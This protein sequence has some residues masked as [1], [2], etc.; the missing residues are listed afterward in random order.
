M[1]AFSRSVE[2]AARPPT[3]WRHATSRPSARRARGPV[4]TYDGVEL[5]PRARHPSSQEIRRRQRHREVG[6]DLGSLVAVERRPGRPRRSP[7]PGGSSRNREPSARAGVPPP[8]NSAFVCSEHPVDDRPRRHVLAPDHTM[9]PPPS[10]R[11]GGSPRPG[12]DGAVRA[13]KVGAITTDRLLRRAPMMR[14]RRDARRGSRTPPRTGTRGLSSRQRRWSTERRPRHLHERSS[15]APPMARERDRAPLRL[16]TVVNAWGARGPTSDREIAARICVDRRG[17][18]RRESSRVGH[19]MATVAHS[20][21]EQIGSRRRPSRDD[22]T[23]VP[24]GRSRKDVTGRT[25]PAPARAYSARERR[26]RLPPR[27]RAAQPQAAVARVVGLLR[28]LRLRR[29]PRHRVQRDPRG[30]RADRRQPALQ[31]RRRRPRCR[32]PRRPGDHPRRD[33]AHA[34]P[35]H[36][37]AV[38]RRAR[39]GHR[40]RDGPSPRRRLVPLDRGG[41]PAPL[42]PDER[43]RARRDDRRRHRADGGRRAPGPAVAGGARGGDRPVVRGSRLLPP[44]RRDDRP[45]RKKVAIDVS[46]TGYTGDLG[47]ELWV[48]AGHAVALWD[49][50][51]AGARTTRSG[52]PGCSRSTSSGS[53]PG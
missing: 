3:P 24:S 6:R 26:N 2:A 52:R 38:V 44:A 25:G 28:V 18:G 37:H 19:R 12:R 32:P 10:D 50:L 45:G 17:G 20:R 7:T 51:W 48:D 41:P 11:V 49:A 42:A 1:A 5:D 47:Y 43:D 21:A 22:L 30:G 40:R 8:T 14:L 9:S 46:R 33:E 23:H 27:H 35:G 16:R 4:A 39:Q 15:R 34:R 31:V 13:A 53:R 29:R 36:L